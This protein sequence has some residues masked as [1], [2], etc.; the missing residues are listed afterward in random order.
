MSSWVFPLYPTTA[1]YQVHVGC[2]PDRHKEQTM[3]TYNCMDESQKHCFE[4]KKADIQ[5]TKHSMIPFV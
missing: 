5:K 4:Q 3:I 2:P 1:E